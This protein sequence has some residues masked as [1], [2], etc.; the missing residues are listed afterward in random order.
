MRLGSVNITEMYNSLAYRQ[1][2]SSFALKISTKDST[3]GSHITPLTEPV[4]TLQ[5]TNARAQKV[6][7]LTL[8]STSGIHRHTSE[9]AKEAMSFLWTDETLGCKTRLKVDYPD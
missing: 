6:C 4:R 5:M 7:N 1:N 3:K 8:K 2:T 9:W